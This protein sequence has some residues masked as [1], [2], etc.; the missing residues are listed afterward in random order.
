MTPLPRIFIEVPVTY[1]EIIEVLTKLGYHPEFDGKYNRY[2]NEKYKS[3]VILPN[4][5]LD[6]TMEI[7]DVAVYARRLYRQGVIKEE[8]NL[9]KK[10]QANR[11]KKSQKVSHKEP[12]SV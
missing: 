11:L 7:V 3:I 5:G 8:E 1:R 9:I 10:I 12:M 6:E 4:Q 2:I